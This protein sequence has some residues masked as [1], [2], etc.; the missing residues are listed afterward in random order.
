MN[1][2]VSLF[3]CLCRVWA[4]MF[5]IGLATMPHGLRAGDDAQIATP[6]PSQSQSQPYDPP[7]A[8]ASDQAQR[9]IRS[10]RVPRGLSVELFAAE[11]LL[12]NPVAFCLDEKGVVYVAETFRLN[13]GV[14]DT[15]GHMNW[16]DADLACR[17]VADRVAMYKKYLGKDFASY[18]IHHDRVRRIVDR[19]GDGRADTATVF[20]DGFNQAAVGLGAGVLAYKGDVWFACIPWLM[21]LR[22]TNGDG[23]ADVRTILHE[24]YGVHVGFLGHDLHGLCI[25]PDGRL[26]FSIGDRGFDVTTLDGHTLAVRDT[27]S[28]LRCNLDGSDLEVFA[29][30]LRNPQE[31]AF[32]EYGN[33]FTGEN[34]SDSGD[35][36]RWAYLVEGGDSGWRIGYQF[37]ESPISRGP[38]NEE[39]LWYPA[40]RG[41][42]AYIVPPIANI[43]D[44][45]SGLTYDPGVT[46]LSPEF[47]KHFFLV[48]FRGSSG[49]SGIRTFSL[50]P[51]GARFRNGQSAA[52]CLVG[53]RHRRRLRAGW[54]ALLQ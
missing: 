38:W 7:L 14:T 52:I 21:K 46:L 12:A 42:A 32:D 53:A 11:P 27:G 44:G 17:T 2:V 49:Q 19:D 20:A 37:I 9:A 6:S 30:G 34:N 23:R 51:Q 31:L 39:K 13:A 8:P 40:F 4:W 48:D 24:G 5:V 35:K 3:Q 50:E 45:P 22:D 1:P 33:L 25:G 15:R 26:Y 29:T 54:C 36:A 16:L 47:K 28:V 41:Q 10:F 18:N 43:A